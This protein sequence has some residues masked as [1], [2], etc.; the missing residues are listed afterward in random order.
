MRSN[1]VVWFRERLLEDNLVQRF[2]LS[3][4]DEAHL[5]LR[6]D[7]VLFGEAASHS[8]LREVRVGGA[9]GRIV[10]AHGESDDRDRHVSNMNGAL[11]RFE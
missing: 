2:R 9:G 7:H 6:F 4:N 8:S 1:V 11:A 5:P 10:D 3:P